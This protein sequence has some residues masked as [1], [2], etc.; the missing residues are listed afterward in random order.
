MH[1]LKKRPLFIYEMANNHMGDVE[2]GIRIVR[3]LKKASEGY[4]SSIPGA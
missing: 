1:Q 2:H 3:E 4:P